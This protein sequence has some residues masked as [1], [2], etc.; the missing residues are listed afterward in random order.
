MTTPLVLQH[1][2]HPQQLLLLFHGVGATPHDMAPLGQHLAQAFPAACVVC[3]AAPQAC[4]LGQG[5]QWFSVTGVTED[6]RPQR[7][8][9]ALPGFVT[10]V[11]QWQQNTGVTEQGTALIGFSQGAIMALEST[12]QGPVLAGRVVALSGRFAQRPQTAPTDTTLH[13][14]HGKS[15]PVIHYGYTVA[16]AERLLEL[17]ADLTADVIPFLGHQINNAVADLV[18]ERLTGYLPQR[19]WQEALRAAQDCPPPSTPGEPDAST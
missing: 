8:A 11:R 15:D 14:V 4:D 17:G 7:V 3:I 5:Y 16:A 19:R 13:L 10:T 1:P 12:Q 9:A 18:L 6:N 2:E